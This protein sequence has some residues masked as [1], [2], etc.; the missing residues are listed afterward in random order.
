MINIPPIGGKEKLR[1]VTNENPCPVCEGNH[2]CSLG[3]GGLIVCGRRNG[4][5][6]GFRHLGP[7]K[8]DPQFHLYRRDDDTPPAAPT[9]TSKPTPPPDWPA[10]A[11]RFA[12]AVTPPYRAK[13]SEVLRLPVD[14]LAALP[15]LG[16]N[17]D[18]KGHVTFPEAD[19]NGVIIGINRRYGDGTKKAMKG[20]KR[21][22]TLPT[23]WRDRPGPLFVVEGPTDTLAATFAGL[24]AVGRPSNVGGVEFLAALLAD[25][26]ADRELI[27][28]GE[29]DQKENGAWPGRDGAEK[30]ARDLGVRLSCPVKLAFP[31]ADAKDV[32]D[33][34]TAEARGEA[35]WPARGAELADLLTAA[36]GPPPEP[37]TPKNA[38]PRI[39]IQT[40]EHRVNDEAAVALGAEPD[41]YQRG[42]LLVHVV[43]QPDEPDDEALI[44]RPAGAPAVR[45]LAVRSSASGSL[46]LRSGCSGAGL[47]RTRSSYPPTHRTGASVPSTP[48]GRGP[49]SV[50]STAL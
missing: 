11:A 41:V 5:V 7:A 35:T 26:P 13:L 2:K 43:P 30:V 19:A 45:E 16:W 18:S 6:P 31:P 38:R 49:P 48:A 37:D 24:A 28:L 9:P 12:G 8:G 34:L 47:A 42:G 23:G 22:L 21:G 17:K 20:G 32:R 3:D 4:P 50:P 33:W 27:I 29:N 46:A 10:L 44:R 1:S 36:A 40:D 39:I 15:M 25:W 14:A